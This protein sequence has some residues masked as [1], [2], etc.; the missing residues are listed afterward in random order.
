MSYYFFSSLDSYCLEGVPPFK[1]R[2]DE[3]IEVWH[4]LQSTVP[5][6][7]FFIFVQ[8]KVD[9]FEN[10]IAKH[11]LDKFFSIVKKENGSNSQEALKHLRSLF[12]QHYTRPLPLTFHCANC[13]D[14]VVVAEIW[15]KIKKAIY[16][17]LLE[18][19]GML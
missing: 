2:I 17:Q 12:S 11:P 4:S 1:Y 19:V 15:G 6:N 14:A 5:Q 7:V 8:N 18:H 9:V 16:R 10:I 13:L 3:E